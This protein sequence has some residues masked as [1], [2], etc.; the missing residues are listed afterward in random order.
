MV[1]CHSLSANNYANNRRINRAI[2]KSQEHSGIGKYKSCWTQESTYV[3][4]QNGPVKGLDGL[5]GLING[6]HEQMPGQQI[7]QRSKVDAHHN[8]GRFSW[9]N[10]QD[11]GEKIEG[12]DYF[13]YN[14]QNKITRIIGFFGPF[15]DL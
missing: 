10:I 11:N 12:M 13:E 14:D 15:I 3:D 9:E 7:Q 8:G 4:S 1:W 2:W 5:A 6:F